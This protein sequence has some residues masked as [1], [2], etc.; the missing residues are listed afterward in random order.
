MM[1][2]CNGWVKSSRIAEGS[3]ESDPKLIPNTG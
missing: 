2:T 1:V 3:V